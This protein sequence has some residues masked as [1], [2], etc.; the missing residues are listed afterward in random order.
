MHQSQPGQSDDRTSLS[1]VHLDGRTLEG[2]GQLVRIAVA[3]SALTGQPIVVDHVRGNRQGK[4]G[5]KSSH[6]AAI[7]CLAEVSGSLVKGV[8][9]GSR[10]FSFYPQAGQMPRNPDHERGETIESDINIALKTPGSVF[11]VFQ[12]LY[13]YFLH[14]GAF[15]S[16]PERQITLSI[17]GG[18]NVSFSPSYDYV[19]QVLVPNLTR[20]GLPRL[21]VHLIRRGWVTGPCTLGKVMLIVDPLPL[22]D[23]SNKIGTFPQFPPVDLGQYQRGTINQV[24]ITVLAPDDPFPEEFGDDKPRS[25]KDPGLPPRPREDNGD[26]HHG[27]RTIRQFVEEETARSV[28]DGLKKLPWWIFTSPASSS[29]AARTDRQDNDNDIPVQVHMTEVTRHYSNLYVLIVAH[30]STG[31]KVGHDAIWGGGKKGNSSARQTRHKK[32]N[33]PSEIALKVKNLVERCV[34]GFLQELYDPSLRREFGSDY[35]GPRQPCVDQFCRDQVVVFEALGRL[36]AEPKTDNDSGTEDERYW[37]LH[38][39]TALWVCEK[40]L[41]NQAHDTI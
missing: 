32:R 11:L 29:I 13:P 25:T 20:I 27:T 14:A 38:M 26:S 40:M 16:A 12:A 6:A 9:V 17:V 5:L 36:T 8:Q 3:L 31:F 7:N 39:R 18:T 33:A 2:G 22:C 4:P 21:S 24:E 28:R 19:A 23:G 10:S 35:V 41:S 15:L 1:T 37:S 30:T 34:D